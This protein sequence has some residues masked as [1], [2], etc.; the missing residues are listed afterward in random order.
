M[1][2]IALI[3]ARSGSKGIPGKNFRLLGG[4]TLVGHAAMCAQAAGCDRVIVSSD[5][6]VEWVANTTGGDV[7]SAHDPQLFLRPAEL[8]QDDTPMIAVVQHALQQLPGAPDDVIVL[9]QPTQPLR[10]PDHIRE[11]VRLLRETQ[12]DSVV[13]V[14]ELPL[15]HSPDM[16]GQVF[17]GELVP[18]MADK[19]LGFGRWPT[20]RQDARPAVKRDGTVYAFRRAT[21]GQ[22]NGLYGYRSV[23]L[24]IDP[25]DSCELDTE[26]DWAALE[27][28]WEARHAR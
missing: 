28:R 20:R 22:S 6:V 1:S 11:A 17:D 13:S 10:K 5:R 3:P 12:A 2:V 14:V 27:Q 4:R 19:E 9:L 18:W 25:I 21:I 24:L 16:L 15:T 7:D 26:A 8:A 23:P